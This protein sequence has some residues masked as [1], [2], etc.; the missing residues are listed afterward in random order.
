MNKT[1]QQQGFVLAS[2]LFVMFFIVAAGLVT[3]Q[4]TLNNFRLSTQEYYRTNTQFAADAGLDSA[5]TQL[6]QDASWTGTGG[7]ITLYSDSSYKDTYQTTIVNDTDPYIKYIDVTAKTYSPPTSSTPKVQRKFRVQLRGVSS[8]SYSLVTGVG[9][10]FMSNNSKIVGGNVYVNG[11]ISM[12]NS[13]QIGLTTNPVNVKAA[14]QNCPVPANSTYPRVCAS[15]ENGQPIN[16]QNTAKIYGEV[17]G[18]N[19]T[20]GTNM[21]NPGLVPGS[22]APAALPSHDRSSITG[23]IASNQTGAVA[24]CSSGTKVW[25]AGLKITGDVTVSGTCQV[26]VQGSIWVT[27]SLTIRNSGKLIVSNAL[28]TPPEIMIDAQAGLSMR[29]SATLQSN[30]AAS[31][32]G[33]RVITYWSMAACS[34]N[35]PDVTGTDL[36]NSRNTITIDLDNSASGPQTEFYARWS[37]VTINNSGNIGALVGQT[38]NLSNSGTITFGTTVTGSFGISAWV[39][40][41]YKRTY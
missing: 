35:C 13:A 34:P 14:H 30:T 33:F 6:N 12:T 11:E 29:N 4:L 27:G 16:L 17:Q 38:V 15:G 24:G 40:D 3:A 28:A 21:L 39:V 5:I 19:Q 31:P 23:A 1:P 36:Y 41:S 10:L 32:V 25:P 8:G 26:T 2:L 20:T 37:R 9:G 18:T 7:E 22:P